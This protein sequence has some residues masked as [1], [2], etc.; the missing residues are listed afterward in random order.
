[1]IMI[2]ITIPVK[3]ITRITTRIIKMMVMK[4]RIMVMRIRTEAT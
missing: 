4:N 1:M 3:R 2:T